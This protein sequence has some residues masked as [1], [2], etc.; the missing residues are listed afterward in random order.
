MIFIFYEAYELLNQ[1][2]PCYS[3]NTKE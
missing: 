1:T 3:R 2:F